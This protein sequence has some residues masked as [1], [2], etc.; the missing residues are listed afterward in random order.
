MKLVNSNSTYID[1]DLCNS[2]SRNVK[3]WSEV[4]EDKF[5]LDKGWSVGH[6]TTVL[7]IDGSGGSPALGLCLVPRIRALGKEIHSFPVFGI[8]KEGKLTPK[9]K[10]IAGEIASR[11]PTPGFTFHP[12]KM[13]KLSSLKIEICWFDLQYHRALCQAC[14]LESL[15]HFQTLCQIALIS[16]TSEAHTKPF[17]LLSSSSHSS[18]QD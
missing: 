6:L 18:F 5:V 2:K 10:E 8:A 13:T 11:P 9:G 16:R 15:S 7:G 3:V 14:V 12:N 1:F 17:I 4:Q